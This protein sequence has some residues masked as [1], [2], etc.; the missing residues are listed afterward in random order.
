MYLI[1]NINFSYNKT[2]KHHTHLGGRL[3]LTRQKNI[4]ILFG[5][6]CYVICVMRRSC[7]ESEK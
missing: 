1:I 3:H 4:C 5:D 6:N 7:K 2:Q